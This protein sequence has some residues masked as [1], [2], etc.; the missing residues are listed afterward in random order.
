MLNST[1]VYVGG[2]CTLGSN[3]NSQQ[4]AQIIMLNDHSVQ[5]SNMLGVLCVLVLLARNFVVP[6]CNSSMYVHLLF[7]I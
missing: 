1:L 5:A 2:P 4:A 7:N 6:S 3:S